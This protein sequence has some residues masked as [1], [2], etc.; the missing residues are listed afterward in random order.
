[1]PGRLH[2]LLHCIM[3]MDD[4][5]FRFLDL[6]PELRI[7]ILSYFLRQGNVITVNDDRCPDSDV[8]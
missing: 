4:K 7:E 5:P 2:F 1:M 6:P 3:T 8:R